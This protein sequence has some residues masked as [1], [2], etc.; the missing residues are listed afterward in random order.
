MW[1]HDKTVVDHMISRHHRGT[2]LM[3]GVLISLQVLDFFANY[4]TDDGIKN[5][6]EWVSSAAV[7]RSAQLLGTDQQ[8]LVVRGRTPRGP[9]S[10]H[11]VPL[12]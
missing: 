7:A 9:G 12:V 4:I 11:D 1:G 3:S 5:L 6:C 10:D 2:V 8:S